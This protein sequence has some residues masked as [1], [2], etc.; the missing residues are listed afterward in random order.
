MGMQAGAPPALGRGP[1]SAGGLPIMLSFGQG[2][3]AQ[4]LHQQ[5]GDLTFSAQV[6]TLAKTYGIELLR[7]SQ[8]GRFRVSCVKLKI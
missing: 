5:M 8:I 6:G 2:F 3:P 1:L 7:V 4:N